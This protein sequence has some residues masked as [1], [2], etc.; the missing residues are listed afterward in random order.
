MSTLILLGITLAIIAI[1]LLLKPEAGFDFARK[2]FLKSGFQYGTVAASL[3]LA[4]AI[5]YS[6]ASSKFPALFEMLALF[7]IVGGVICVLLPPSIFKSIVSWE[8]NIFSPYGRLL[9]IC[10]GLLGG[11]LLY[12]AA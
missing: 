6:A 9:G 4:V 11:F 3:I 12:A 2:Y 5:Y 1:F 8:L 7:S 10:Y